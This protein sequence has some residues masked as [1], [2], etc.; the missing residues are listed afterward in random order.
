MVSPRTQREMRSK[1]D[2]CG[3]SDTVLFAGAAVR[4]ISVKIFLGRHSLWRGADNT[5]QIASLKSALLS[6]AFQIRTF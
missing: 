3:R 4:A 5:V 1:I 2:G 6:F